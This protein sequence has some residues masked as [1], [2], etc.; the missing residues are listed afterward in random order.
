[1][2]DYFTIVELMQTDPIWFKMEFGLSLGVFCAPSS[3]VIQLFVVLLLE[4]IISRI[5]QESQRSGKNA[6]EG[7]SNIF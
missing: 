5:L 3:L 2:I 4:K 1:L 6:K 7:S